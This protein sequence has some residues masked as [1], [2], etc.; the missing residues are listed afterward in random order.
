MNRKSFLPSSFLVLILNLWVIFYTLS[1]ADASNFETLQTAEGKVLL[2]E[3]DESHTVD[4][5]G[6]IELR[7]PFIWASE[8]FKTCNGEELTG[9]EDLFAGLHLSG[10]LWDK[11]Q[12]MAIIDNILVKKGDTVQGAVVLTI[13]RDEVL[14]GR[15]EQQ[16]FLGFEKLFELDDRTVPVENRVGSE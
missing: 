8:V 7:N 12:P 13:Y 14:L 15:E 10:I 9:K 3:R 6:D 1:I 16:H 4:T 11:K 2:T 5:S